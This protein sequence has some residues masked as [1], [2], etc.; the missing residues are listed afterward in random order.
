MVRLPGCLSATWPKPPSARPWRPKLIFQ[1]E[2]KSESWFCWRVG[3]LSESAVGVG[4]RVSGDVV[5]PQRIGNCDPELSGRAEL[6]QGIQVQRP[7]WVRGCGLRQ[8]SPRT[9]AA[10][11]SQT[12]SDRQRRIRHT[13]V[14]SQVGAQRYLAVQPVVRTGHLVHG[15]PVARHTGPD[16]DVGCVGPGGAQAQARVDF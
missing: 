16:F 12:S 4:V 15:R 8:G 10:S 5:R 7:Q 11:V 3:R 1:F 2:S 13:P 9:H 6:P 14:K